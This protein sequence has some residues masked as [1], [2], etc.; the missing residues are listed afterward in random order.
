[1]GSTDAMAAV[2]TAAVNLI[3]MLVMLKRTEIVLRHWSLASL[4]MGP[5]VR[6]RRLEPN[7]DPRSVVS[8][9]ASEKMTV[10]VIDRGGWRSLMKERRAYTEL[11]LNTSW[12]K[13]L[14]L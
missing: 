1:M 8:S 9:G 10:I 13:V 11:E 14:E 2:I 4:V 6:K 3:R 5:M 12:E 7:E